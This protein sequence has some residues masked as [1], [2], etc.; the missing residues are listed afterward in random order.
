M[1]SSDRAV[2]IV[3]AGLA[4]LTVAHL[5]H[6]AGLD[7]RLLEARLRLGGRILSVDEKGLPAGD[8]FD[9]GPSWFWP[10]MQPSLGRLVESLGLASFAQRSDGDVLFHRFSR[11]AP[12]RFGGVGQAPVSMRVVGGTASIVTALAAG[13]P[14]GSIELGARATAARLDGDEVE[15]SFVDGSG[16]ERMDRSSQIVFALPPRLLEATVSFTPG[17]DAVSA[18]RWRNTPTWMAPHAKFFAVYDRPFWR[19]KGLSGTAQSMVGPLVE[20]HDATTASGKAALFG[21][22]GLS[23]EDRASQGKDAIVASCVLQL[24]LLF[25]PEAAEPRATLIKDW[26]T[27]PLTATNRD[28][29]AAGHPVAD[30]RPWVGER[31]RDHIVLAG[32][33][34]SARE[35]GYLAGAVNA[36]EGAA[37]S[38]IARLRAPRPQVGSRPAQ[39]SEDDHRR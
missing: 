2:L 31:W 17:I 18:R 21:F 28:R 24:A 16:A 1:S 37:A 14:E 34:T 26:A 23:G 5:I 38:L 9:L 35:P 20:I 8:G 32:S 3:G 27:D 29:A 4:G 15:L 30:R 11:E 39:S 22:L 36:A 6:R 25:G 12:Q 13:L 10:D 19:E 7:F 33:E